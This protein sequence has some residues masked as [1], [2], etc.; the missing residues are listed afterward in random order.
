MNK[1]FIKIKFFKNLSIKSISYKYILCNKIVK[2]EI[3][4]LLKLK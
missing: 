3:K 1:F 2:K 4:Y